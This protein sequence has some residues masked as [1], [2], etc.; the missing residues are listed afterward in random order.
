MSR[1]VGHRHG[2]DLALLWLWC[3]PAAIALFRPLAWEP[4]YASGV[5]LKSWKKKKKKSSSSTWEEQKSKLSRRK[6]K[7]KRQCEKEN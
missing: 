7:L 4:P 2:L 6:E 1:G 3:R 5:A